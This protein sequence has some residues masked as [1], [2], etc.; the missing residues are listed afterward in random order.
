MPEPGRSARRDAVPVVCRSGGRATLA[1]DMLGEAG[2][3][4]ACSISG[5]MEGARINDPRSLIHRMRVVN[6][7]RSAGLPWA[8]DPEP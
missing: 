2:C 1:V 8:H 5:G 7:G 6:G 4:H 3:H